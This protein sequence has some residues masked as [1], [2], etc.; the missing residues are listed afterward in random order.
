M[1]P[2]FLLSI[3]VPCYNEAQNIPL[4]VEKLS[5][6]LRAYHY[7]IILVND[8]STDQ[9]QEIIE[10]LSIENKNV[11]FISFSRNFGHQKAIKAGIDFATG[12]AMVTMDADL[13]HPAETIP[14]MINLWQ[15]GY[16]V[17][18]AVRDSQ[19]QP[20]WVKKGASK[21]FYWVLSKISNQKVIANSSDFRLFDKK[22]ANELRNMPEQDLYLRGLIPWIGFKQTTLHY[23]ESKRAFGTSKYNFKT[24]LLLASHGITSSSIK[25][26]RFALSIGFLF[27]FLAFGYG[28]YAIVVML[29]GLTVSG[30]TSIVASIMFLS[31]IQLIVLGVIGEYLGKLYMAHKQRPSYIIAHTNINKSKTLT[32]QQERR[33]VV[34]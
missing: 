26:L 18:T 14:K 6:V 34:S 16:D 33:A 2:S 23:I 30:W 19:A 12:D 25:P 7:E 4:L 3:I 11:K 20:S 15:Q 8:G 27:A 32:I 24:M 9:T 13:Q 17:I 29:M 5:E 1:K 28:I 10:L 31:G 21:L 22:I